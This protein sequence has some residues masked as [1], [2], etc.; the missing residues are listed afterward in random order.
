MARARK[1]STDRNTAKKSMAKRKAPRKGAAKKKRTARKKTTTIS[2]RRSSGR[3]EKFDVDK[4]AKTTGRSGVPFLMAR[5]VAKNVTKKIKSE[6]RVGRKEEKTMTAG[7]VRN[8]IAKELRDRN[9]QTIA[10]SYAGEAPENTQK[11]TM[12]AKVEPHDPPV[13]SADT[14]QHEAYRADRDSVMHDRSKR[15]T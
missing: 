12:A 8:M 1:K 7:R 4:M 9:E 13:G 14:N 5:D 2:V 15:Y 10:S 3:K 6:A 11:D